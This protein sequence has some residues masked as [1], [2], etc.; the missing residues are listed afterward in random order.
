MRRLAVLLVFL[1]GFA[2]AAEDDLDASFGK[3]VLIIQ[4]S[5]FA[6]H[7][8]DIYIA[9]NDAQRARGLMFVH[10]LPTTT[11]MLFVYET[12]QYLS[13]W[14]KN[15]FIPLDMLFVRADGTVSSVAHDTEPQ[16]L[17]SISALEPVRYVLEINA[18]LAEKL[19]IDQYS[20]LLW[21]GI[22]NAQ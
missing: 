11:G 13:M 16:S 9:A 3:G 1:A 17:R 8:F 5:Q 21:D 12:D 14:M 19:S 2:T 22:T 7:H 6:C 15:T 18:G 10:D 20:R 4:A